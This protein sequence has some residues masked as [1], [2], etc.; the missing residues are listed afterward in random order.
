MTDRPPLTLEALQV[1]DAIARRGSY[2]AAAEEL[3]RVPSALSYIIQNLEEKL[4]VTIFSKQGRKAVLTAAGNHLLNEGRT[5]LAAVAKLG[6]TTRNIANGWESTLR[7]AID[8][9][10]NDANTFKIIERFL[11]IYPEIEIDLREEV[12]SGA[13]EALIT[14]QVDLLIGASG[15]V[16]HQKGIHAERLARHDLVYAVSPNHPLAHEAQPISLER[17][18]R[19]RTIVVHDSALNAIPWTKGLL[20]ETRYF[21]VPTVDC[22]IRAQLAGIGA[23]HLPRQRVQPY[24]DRGELVELRTE[25]AYPGANADIYIAWKVVNRGKGLRALKD[26]FLQA[27]EELGGI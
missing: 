25:Q 20:T 27:P 7:I 14:D 1:L 23:G 21:Y 17:L 4:G 13:W 2:A 19:E 26:C 24:L 6:E 9:M 11:S 15:P 5:V 10:Y 18:A 22:K 12:M 8:S 3:K 16:P